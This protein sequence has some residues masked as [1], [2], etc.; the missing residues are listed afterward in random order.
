MEIEAITE[1]PTVDPLAEA[2]AG[3]DEQ[4]NKLET[5]DPTEAV[6]TEEE[7]AE[8]QPQDSEVDEAEGEEESDTEEEAEAEDEEAEETEDE[9]SDEPT[10]IAVPLPEA[11]QEQGLEAFN[12][13]TQA[14][15]DAL[16]ALTNS[17]ESKA[18]RETR[19]RDFA[20]ATAALEDELQEFRT[21]VSVEPFKVVDQILA[22]GD[23]AQADDAFRHYILAEPERWN[24]HLKW[25]DSLADEGGMDRARRELDLAYRERV[26]IARRTAQA[27]AD[28]RKAASVLN[29]RL[30]ELLENVAEADH[31]FVRKGI[32]AD[33]A[34]A[35]K[36]SVAKGGSD[37]ITVQQL[38]DI[39]APW[40]NRL[41]SSDG[42]SENGK[43]A[44]TDPA[45]QTESK[46]AQQVRKLV[47]VRKEGRKVVKPGGSPETKPKSPTKGK[48]LDEVVGDLKSGK[49][50]VG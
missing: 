29:N 48:R 2:V 5:E 22:A 1:E 33:V 38:D 10:L 27:S 45:V 25:I 44:D 14:E 30:G 21:L 32:M 20:D 3:A 35:S 34:T 4:L 39:A 15:A 9:D 50:S 49:L 26:D 37:Q 47:S 42:V 23:R 28:E 6:E 11:L 41:G 18:E 7:V 36:A 43:D 31:D 19:E 8:E 46:G 40:I 24:D 17:Y 13:E 16:T 12:V